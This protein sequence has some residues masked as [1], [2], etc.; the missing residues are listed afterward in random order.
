MVT[1]NDTESGNSA[2]VPLYESRTLYQI[3]IGLVRENPDQPRKST[4]EL[5]DFPR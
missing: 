3:P 4:C 2:A 1:L 5:P